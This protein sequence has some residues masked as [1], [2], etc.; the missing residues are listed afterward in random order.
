MKRGI[1]KWVENEKDE[2]ARELESFMTN[3]HSRNKVRL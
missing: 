3:I 2:E 1:G